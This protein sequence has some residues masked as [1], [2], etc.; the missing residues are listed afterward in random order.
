MKLYIHTY[1]SCFIPD[2]GVTEASQTFHQDTH[3]LQ[4]VLSMRNMADVTGGKSVAVRS[5]SISGGSAINP[6]V[7]F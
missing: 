5:Q 7:T 4:N 3:V 6:L 1:H 2:E